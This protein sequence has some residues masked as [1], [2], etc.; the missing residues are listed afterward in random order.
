MVSPCSL[1]R[2]AVGMAHVSTFTLTLDVSTWCIC[3]HRLQRG[4]VHFCVQKFLSG[5][6]GLVYLHFDLMYDWRIIHRNVIPVCCRHSLINILPCS[7]ENNTCL[8]FLWAFCCGFCYWPPFMK[9]LFHIGI[10]FMVWY[11][12]TTI[13]DLEGWRKFSKWINF[14]P[15]TPSIWKKIHGKASQNFFS[16][17]RCA[18]C[19]YYWGALNFEWIQYFIHV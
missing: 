3:L 9:S 16:G 19:A 7:L 10:K 18:N 8:G 11:K 4:A 14:F 5:L 1:L 13:N 15:G 12:G 2:S 6:A 17:V